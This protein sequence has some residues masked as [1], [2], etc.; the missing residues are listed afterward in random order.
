V[1]ECLKGL[2]H[3]TGL[4]TKARI[5][6]RKGY[7]P[8]EDI[9]HENVH[10]LALTSSIQNLRVSEMVEICYSSLLVLFPT[11]KGVHT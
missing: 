5:N 7:R 9:L 3:E 6:A 8:T 10:S 11:L 2:L 1:P 4:P